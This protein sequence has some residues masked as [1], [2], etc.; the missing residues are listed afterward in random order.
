MTTAWRNDVA[1]G[2][3]FRGFDAPFDQGLEQTKRKA[4]IVYM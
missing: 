3:V 2:G 1:L 4:W